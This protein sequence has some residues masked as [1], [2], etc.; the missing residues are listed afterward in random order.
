VCIAETPKIPAAT[1]GHEQKGCCTRPMSKWWG[2]DTEEMVG[3]S[4]AVAGTVSETCLSAQLVPKPGQ[5]G[6]Q[7]RTEWW[8]TTS[9]HKRNRFADDYTCSLYD[10]GVG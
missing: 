4:A 7:T 8:D 3:S 10:A 2:M 1:V 5:G 9:S 6:R